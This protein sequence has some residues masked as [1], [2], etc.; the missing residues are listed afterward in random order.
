MSDLTQPTGEGAHP[1]R[2]SEEAFGHAELPS[3]ANRT[4]LEEAKAA[5]QAYIADEALEL[6]S[7][8]DVRNLIS[9]FFFTQIKVA[10]E[11]KRAMESGQ[12]SSA[13]TQDIERFLDIA[14]S[15]DT[16]YR[17]LDDLDEEELRA[18][19]DA[20]SRIRKIEKIGKDIAEKYEADPVET[21]R[22]LANGIKQGDPEALVKFAN[23]LASK[24]FEEQKSP[25]GMLAEL[26]PVF[27]MQAAM[28][29]DAPPV[30]Q[31]IIDAVAEHRLATGPSRRIT[32]RAM[33]IIIESQ[34]FNTA[35]SEEKK[36]ELAEAA[37]L[38]ATR[39]VLPD[40]DAYRKFYGEEYPAASKK[41]FESCANALDAG[42]VTAMVRS[43]AFGP[44]LIKFQT[45]MQAVGEGQ[46]LAKIVQT[47]GEATH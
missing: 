42:P 27:D 36:L 20:R 21:L 4:T 17:P 24:T 28:I 12:L 15:V 11:Q 41:F 44:H 2:G 9:T 5:V 32:D 22:K 10:E 45:A 43:M 31:M 14:S 8:K 23:D 46:R 3:P 18:Y 16:S 29:E 25:L 6:F 26:K 1:E 47:Y 13:V 39:Q 19:S 35:L 40:A 34:E 37:Y 38:A 33:E 30:E 7:R